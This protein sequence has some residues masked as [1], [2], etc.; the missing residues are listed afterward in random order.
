M[1]ARGKQDSAITNIGEIEEKIFVIR[2]Q[3][4]ML[5]SDLAEVYGVETRRLKE[6]VRRNFNRFPKDFMF[7]LS[8]DEMQSI[9]SLR[10]QIATLNEG[11][12]KR[13]RHSKYAPFAFTEHGAVM[14]AS[15][16]NSPTAVEASIVVVRAFVKM[17][18]MLEL[19]QDLADRVEELEKTTDYHG[20]KFGV[21][22]G[23]L[24]Q[25]MRDPKYLKRTI[26]FVEAKNAKVKK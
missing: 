22:S 8:L 20:E 19:Y 4:V 11:D 2:G 12:S 7:E 16:L 21:V 17:R 25:I 5:D 24:S 6:Q 26:G 3:R 23:L 9:G 18:A 13:G 15:V 10:S 14:L 1:R